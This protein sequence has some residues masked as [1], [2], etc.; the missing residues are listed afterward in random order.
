MREGME[1][2]GEIRHSLW[3]Q[4]AYGLEGLRDK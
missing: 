2:E 4:S 1:S 3:Y